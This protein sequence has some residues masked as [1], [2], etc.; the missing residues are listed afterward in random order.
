MD[1]INDIP[2][3]PQDTILFITLLVGV[4]SI[5]LTVVTLWWQRTHDR[6]MVRPIGKFQTI[7]T[8]MEF[9]IAIE[10][11]GI[12]PLIIKSVNFDKFKDQEFTSKITKEWPP[13]L[14]EG[15]SDH[16]EICMMRL[17]PQNFAI[18]PGNS[19]YL[20][21]YRISDQNDVQQ[22]GELQSIKNDYGKITEIRLEFTDIYG[23]KIWVEKAP[24]IVFSP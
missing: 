3:N 4:C 18:C 14:L 12:G 24:T 22:K 13:N 20:V 8:D 11:D 16:F 23:K 10:N 1:F 6:L 21:Q 19:I 9:S 2:T 15:T 17:R 5:I 7:N